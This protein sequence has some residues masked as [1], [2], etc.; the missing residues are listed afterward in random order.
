[1]NFESAKGY[2][3]LWIN[4]DLRSEY[5]NSFEDKQLCLDFHADRILEVYQI[6][7]ERRAKKG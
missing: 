5:L 4:S 1:M 2:V 6:L 3:F 7:R